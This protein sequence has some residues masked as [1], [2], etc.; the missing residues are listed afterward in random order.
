M[1]G[2]KGVSGNGEHHDLWTK[3][4][5][6]STTPESHTPTHSPI[7]SAF[8]RRQRMCTLIVCNEFALLKWQNVTRGKTPKRSFCVFLIFFFFFLVTSRCLFNNYGK[9][10]KYSRVK[11]PPL[12]N[13]LS[14]IISSLKPWWLQ[15]GV[16]RR[17]CF[18]RFK[19]LIGPF[20]ALQF[21][22]GGFESTNL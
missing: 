18:S 7:Q 3:Y 10:C 15:I 13:V 21:F 17:K 16:T 11:H 12:G 2:P 14:R 20:L 8:V 1:R 5:K 19:T 4:R 22:G 9:W 6:A